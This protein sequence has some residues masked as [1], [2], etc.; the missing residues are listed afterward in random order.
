MEVS[1]Q[2]FQTEVVERSY[3]APVV[4]D[5]WAEW[6]GPC[7]ALGPVLEKLAAEA[8]GAWTL[9]KVDVDANQQISQALGIQGIPAVKAIKDGKIVA[10]FTGALPEAQ[11]R[12]WLSQLG[13][14]PGEL[15]V[16][17]GM[18]AEVRGDLD[19]AAERYRAALVQE[20]ANTEARA[21]LSRVELQLR[22]GG[23]ES[24]LRARVAKDPRD[25]DAIV[26]LADL[27]AVRGDFEAAVELLIEAVRDST[28]DERERAR[29][30]LLSLL[31][32]LSADDPRATS[33]R[34]SLARVLF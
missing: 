10:E 23:D 5:F 8:N 14:S 34:R 15:L 19:A 24:E 20:P 31:D 3:Q 22:A 25:V 7:R 26:E 4:V 17:E 18:D 33:A 9:A 11:V 28:G 12:E 6:C 16:G 27:L 21:A 2:T 29:T 32:G 13:P 30:H 1:E